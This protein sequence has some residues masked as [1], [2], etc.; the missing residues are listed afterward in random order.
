MLTLFKLAF[1]DVDIDTDILAESPNAYILASIL[2]MMSVSASW[3]SSFTP[4]IGEIR[5]IINIR[6]QTAHRDDIGLL[7]ELYIVAVE[8]DR[9]NDVISTSR[10]RRSGDADDE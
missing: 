9:Q 7:M 3:N 1:H 6:T 8:S 5:I 2:S 10:V 4:L